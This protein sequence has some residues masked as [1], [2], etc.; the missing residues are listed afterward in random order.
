MRTLVL[1][2]VV[3][4]AGAQAPRV[5]DI[6]FYGLRKVTAARILSTLQLQ[7]G[8]RLPA[9]KGDL[10]ER[11]AKIPGVV[12]ARIDAVCCEGQ[13][14]ALFIGI[15]EKGAPL[16]ALRSA[17]AGSATLPPE[18]TD[19]Y[20]EFLTAVERAAERGNAGE[21]LTAGHSMMADPEARAA[22]ERFLSFAA[23]HVQLL[24]E[25]LRSAAEP[26][27]R[28]AAAVV[29]GYAPRKPE[30]VDDLQYA[31]QDPDE[32]V[33]ANAM[34]SLKAIAVLA[35]KQ[36]DLGIRISPTWFVQLLHSIVL[37]DR[38]QSAEALVTLTD[39]GE[40][41]AL[42]Q[43]RAS[44]LPALAEMARWKTLRYALPPFLLLGRVAGM[45]DD[46]VHQ[47]WEKG[48]REPVIRQA[49]GAN[50]GGPRPKR[51]G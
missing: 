48:E 7:S 33:R 26:D 27:E 40:G 19:T 22:Q 6:D 32:S 15:E 9:S 49:L 35:A 5:G 2:A 8:D 13:D 30:V 3:S 24:R 50:G 1:L 14:V 38:V 4:A 41:L 46:Q 45:A 34:R 36:P 20:R 11:I 37:S 29:I 43:I 39:G 23:D 28:A 51:G 47:L 16:P 17:P 44:A 42:D 10:E 21:D 12:Q 31:M 25:V 18:L